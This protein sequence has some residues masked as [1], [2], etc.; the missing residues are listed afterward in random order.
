M[1]GEAGG[2]GGGHGAGA[3]MESREIEI[4]ISSSISSIMSPFLPSS[5]A[6]LY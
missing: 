6:H 1:G 3:C 4:V 5:A 2:G